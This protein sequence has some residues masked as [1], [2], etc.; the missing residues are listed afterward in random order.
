MVQLN[1]DWRY[2]RQNCFDIQERRLA[3]FQFDKEWLVY[4]NVNLSIFITDKC[5]AKCDFCVAELRYVDGGNIYVKPTIQDDEEYFSRIE[6][7]IIRLKPLN[8]SVSV[9]GGE[10]THC[11]RIR[12]VCELLKKHNIRKKTITTNGTG[13]LNDAGDGKIVL[14]VLIENGFQHLNISRAHHDSKANHRLMRYGGRIVELTDENL[15]AISNKANAN[16]LRVRL[17]CVLT[18]EGIHT[19]PEMK[20]YMD[21]AKQMGIDNVVFRELMRYDVDRIAKGRIHTFCEANRV[22]LQGIWEQIDNDKSFVL[23]NQVLGYYYY[24]EVY[25]YNGI[26]MVSESANIQ[27][28]GVEKAKP[29]ETPVVYEMVLHPNGCLNGS[30]REWEDLLLTYEK[31]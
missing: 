12:R 16:G 6:E 10:P 19:I 8:L 28:I 21:F 25:K 17:S 27:Q 13:L 30:W 18:K 31:H 4:G 5:N 3:S 29:A 7:I 20:E 15:S 9:T 22:D 11:K 2:Q 26:D 23:E 1:T 24:V 14:D